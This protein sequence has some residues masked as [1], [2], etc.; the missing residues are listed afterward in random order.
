MIKLIVDMYSKPN[1]TMHSCQWRPTWP[2]E[3]TTNRDERE[4]GNAEIRSSVLGSRDSRQLYRCSVRTSTV[5]PKDDVVFRISR[6]V[7]V[8]FAFHLIERSEGETN[9]P[10]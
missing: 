8:G 4:F 2:Q 5:I 7:C 10:Q 1:E 3:L 6:K 9:F